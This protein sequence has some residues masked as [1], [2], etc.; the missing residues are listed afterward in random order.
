MIEE[1]NLQLF[2]YHSEQVWQGFFCIA[3]PEKIEIRLQPV[4][5]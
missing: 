5:T 1:N 4:Y 2:G 3:G